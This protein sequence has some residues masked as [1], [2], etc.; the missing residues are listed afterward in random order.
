MR[1]QTSRR[2][3]PKRSLKTKIIAWS[4]VPTAIILTAVAWVTFNAYR[5]VTED[6]VVERDRELTH[7]AAG[8]FSADLREYTTLLTEYTGLLAGLPRIAYAYEG[9]LIAPA[10]VL[11]QARSRF[12]VF[13]G[14]VLIISSQG[15][16]I[17]A[18]PERPDVVGQN[19]AG[20]PYV[21]QLLQPS[22]PVFSNIVT[23]GPGGSHVIVVAVPI[24]GDRGQFLGLIAGMFR[25][26]MLAD[27]PL[28]RNI[29]R[30]QFGESSSVYLVDGAGRVIYHSDNRRINQDISE[31]S[32]VRQVLGGQVGAVRTRGFNNRQI[33][34]S[35]APVPG[36][37]WGIIA[38]ESW[39][40]LMRPGENY[41][42]FLLILLALGMLVPALVVAVGVN[43]ITRPIAQLISAAQAVAG[44]DFGQ[45]ITAPTGD[46][47]ETLAEQFNRMSNRLR[48][49][50]SHMRQ[51][52]LDRTNELAALSAIAAVV[53]R[54]LNLDDVLADALRK[55]LPVMQIEAGGIYLVDEAAKQLHL[56]AHQGISAESLTNLQGLKIGQGFSGQVAET[57]RPIVVRDIATDFRL[58]HTVARAE[59]LHSLAAVP[60]QAKEKVLGVLFV[61]THSIREFT[62]QDVGMLTAIGH[63]IGAAIENARLFEAERRRRQQATLLADMARLTSSTLDLNEV[64]R[65]TASC[66][67]D[68]FEV[69]HCLICLLNEP[70]GG[71]RCSI[72]VGFASSAGA[73]IHGAVLQPAA[74]TRQTVLQNLQPL[75]I[76]D[77]AAEPFAQFPE[78][79]APDIQSALVVPLEAGGQQLGL[80]ELG[81]RPPRS[82]RFTAD[83]GALALAMANQA[84]LA[85]QS[86]RLYRQAQEVAAL[87]ER[88]RLA[89]DLHD[90]V[91]QALYGVTLYAKAAAGQ[92]SQGQIE[93]VANH[94]RQL[95]DTAQEALA[96]MRLLI[97]ELRPPILAEEGLVAALQARLQAV[98][99]RAGLKTKL[100]VVGAGQLPP[101]VEE[102]LYRIAQ[103]ALNNALKHAQAQHIAVT[104]TCPPPGQP[105]TL[106]ITDDGIG[107]NPETARATGGMGLQVMAERAA[108]LNGT[109]AINSRPGRGATVRAEIARLPLLEIQ[110]R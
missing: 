61:V 66:A 11:T 36:T 55:T 102:E 22:K 4:F 40:A 41:R 17:A 34:A 46:E 54:S 12:A 25:L 93:T 57:G 43:R 23:D 27:N 89:R 42:R 78:N 24:R 81:T 15:T 88:Q 106:E 79:C 59:G 69:D 85:I 97:Y 95:Q 30:R 109:I 103:E 10:D 13:D 72:E 1:A 101:D 21:R 48:Q 107:F 100:N 86:A 53:S 74:Q 56:A 37:P 49:S 8:E 64:L 16:V 26:G 18:E 98:E 35:F 62:G 90:S 104:L 6:L 44:G 96:E 92:L 76:E 105:I 19:W 108:G 52:L 33:V 3:L 94:L 29:N 31:V 58:A 68:V 5:Q 71:L 63:Q 82:R 80:L 50:Y 70:D 60:V 110:E 84:A 83:E 7:F 91:T 45:T 9:D 75:P 67:V 20:R 51:M 99:G 47:I 28:Y 38:E 39:D 65:L 77:V 32:V 73:A 87:A 2:H 14:G